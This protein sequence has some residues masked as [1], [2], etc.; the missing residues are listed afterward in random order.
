MYERNKNKSIGFICLQIYNLF[1]C[2]TSLKKLE[3]IILDYIRS[4]ILKEKCD[5]LEVFLAQY[6]IC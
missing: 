1:Q 4:E 6:L 5:H 2:K 3:R